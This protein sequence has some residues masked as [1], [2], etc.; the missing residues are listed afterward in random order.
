M[1]DA[2]DLL[3]AADHRVELALPGF[4]HQINAVALERLKFF[5][6]RL[7]RHATAPPHC[8]KCLKNVF[9]IYGV[10]VEQAFGLTVD[11]GKS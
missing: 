2:A 4:F 3:V 10:E 1:H 11:R 6:R 5:F 8:L 9:F 7:I